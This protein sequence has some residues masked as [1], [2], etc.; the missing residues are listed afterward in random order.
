MLSFNNDPKVKADWIAKGKAHQAADMI[1]A[2]TYG[3][4]INGKFKAC[5]I[6]CYAD[7]NVRDKHQNVAD[8]IDGSIRLSHCRDAIFEGLSRI[9]P[10]LG[11]EFHTQWIEA[12]PVGVETSEFE[13]V[14]EKLILKATKWKAEKFGVPDNKHLLIAIKLYERRIAGDDPPLD[15]WKNA[16]LDAS[17]STRAAQVAQVAL[18]AQD[19]LSTLD[20]RYALGRLDDYYI[21]MRDYYL[22]LMAELEVKP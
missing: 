13:R 10:K 11:I 3:Q 2:R 20:V 17:W 4:T 16:A 7:R 18:D 14:A 22:Q 12:I 6:G 21:S 8:Q 1:M 9:D 15:E 5:T 19:A